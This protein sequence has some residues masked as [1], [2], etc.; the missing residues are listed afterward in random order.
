MRDAVALMA[1]HI[2]V[3]ADRANTSGGVV[4][5][6]PNSGTGGGLFTP[7]GT[8]AAPAVQ[9]NGQMGLSISS[10]SRLVSSL[11]PQSFNYL[12]T[13]APCTVYLVA[14]SASLSGAQTLAATANLSGSFSV[15]FYLYLFNTNS[16]LAIGTGGTA[17][18][19]PQGGTVTSGVPFAL[20]YF[21]DVAGSPDYSFKTGNSSV[22]GDLSSP[23]AG[24]ATGAL[25]IGTSPN[26]GLP[27]NIVFF[28]FLSWPR[29]LTT[30]E[31]AT[32]SAYLLAR[33]G[34][35]S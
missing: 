26:G 1:P 10:L 12:H 19:N 9:A 21:C 15:G 11:A 35:A 20:S 31:R 3:R 4:T 13:G 7:N 28:E 8:I 18:T 2:Q 27:A 30:Q 33:Y 24:D 23:S 34:T 29:L 22:T 14:S 32:M 16:F 5:N 25:T 6:V 17:A